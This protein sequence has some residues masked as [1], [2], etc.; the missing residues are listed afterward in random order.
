[1][2]DE[3]EQQEASDR[4]YDAMTRLQ[5]LRDDVRTEITGIIDRYYDRVPSDDA[6]ERDDRGYIRDDLRKVQRRIDETI[7]SL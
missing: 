1:M 6:Y 2:A 3:K 4:H 5:N 7:N